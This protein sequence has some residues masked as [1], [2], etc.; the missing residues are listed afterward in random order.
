MLGQLLAGATDRLSGQAESIGQNL[1]TV[2]RSREIRSRWENEYDTLV[3]RARNLEQQI[4]DVRDQARGIENPLRDW[5]ELERTLARA[6]ERAW[7]R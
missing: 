1:E 7:S 5:P 3:L 2:R 6:R 4:R